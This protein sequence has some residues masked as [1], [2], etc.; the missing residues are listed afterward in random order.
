MNIHQIQNMMN[1]MEPLMADI[2]NEERPVLNSVNIKLWPTGD[3][4][5]TH[6]LSSWNCSKRSIL[7]VILYMCKVEFSPEALLFHDAAFEISQA[8]TLFT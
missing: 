1:L 4:R 6:Y 3:K 2:Y 5:L 7:D 8:F